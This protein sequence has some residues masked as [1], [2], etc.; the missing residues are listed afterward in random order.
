[1]PLTSPASTQ[2]GIYDE[3]YLSYVDQTGN[4]KLIIFDAVLSEDWPQGTT[5]TEHPVEQG[6]NVT[7]HVRV[8]LVT[9]KL[10]VRVTNEPLDSNWIMDPIGGPGAFTSLLIQLP[11][12]SV[13]TQPRAIFDGII[14][15][16]KWDSGL[17]SAVQIGVLAGVASDI[18]AQ[19]ATDIANATPLGNIFGQSLK[20]YLAVTETGN[21]LIAYP[22]VPNVPE[23]IA[24]NPIRSI[25]DVAGNAVFNAIDSLVP[26]GVATMVPMQVQSG[27]V[28]V[29]LTSPTAQTVQFDPTADYATL[30]I[31]T[32]ALLKNQAQTFTVIGSK[33]TFTPMVIEEFTPHRGAPDDT[34]TGVEINLGFKELRIVTTNTVAIV[35]PAPTLPRAQPPVNLGKQDFVFDSDYSKTKSVLKGVLDPDKPINLDNSGAAPAP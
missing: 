17:N 35:L 22:P 2:P 13:P 16:P 12:P 4:T 7:D 19:A 6:A 11:D 31:E 3:A 28:P 33:Q 8:T 1:M 23:A 26:S 20:P 29:P 9:C 5:V 30:M 25:G 27:I 21:E 10:K 14:E 18:A 15:V 34:G 24:G 32:L